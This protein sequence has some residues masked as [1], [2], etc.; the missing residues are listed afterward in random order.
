MPPSSDPVVEM[1][2]NRRMAPSRVAGAVGTIDSLP[3]DVLLRVMSHLNACHAVQTCVLSRR[4]RDL[5][6]SVPRINASYEE[7]EDMADT[8]QECEALFKKFVNRLLMLRNP[9]ALD[10][11]R[12]CYSLANGSSFAALD[13]D[14]AD[15]NLWIG[16]ALQCNARS[17]K[18][19][20]RIEP[21]QLNPAVFTSKYL[22]R[23][24]LYSA[25]LIPGFFRQLQTGCL[26]LDDLFL[27][28]CTIM[29]TEISSQTLKVLTIDND[30]RFSFDHPTSI[31][32]PS[33]ISLRLNHPAGAR[34]PLLKNMASLVMASVSLDTFY[35]N[36]IH[37]DGIQQLLRSLSGVTS[38]KFYY[39]GKQLN[40]EK[41]YGWCPKFCNLINLTLG[42]CCLDPDLYALIVFLQNSP[43][44]EKL[45]LKLAQHLQNLD[46]SARIIGELEE[47]S[48]TCEQLEIVEIICSE[49]DTLL[50]SVEDFLRDSGITSDQIDIYY[51]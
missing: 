41:N 42:E 29:D 10:E 27:C 16:H 13:A 9:V 45:T 32:I 18:V 1:S 24:R 49:D 22:K 48:F 15:A 35:I 37:V 3:D 28:D 50:N 38:L 19:V 36:D 30:C 5:W 12:L 34:V 31:S 2:G 25:D 47:R 6:R 46:T 40:M 21:L 17:V 26:V 51:S 11:F 43:R 7:F 14:S 8:D 39:M 4:W 33:L 20:N 23:L 44:L